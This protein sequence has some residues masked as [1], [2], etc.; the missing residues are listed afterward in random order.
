MSTSGRGRQRISRRNLLTGAGAGL[1][2]TA[3][4]GSPAAVAHGRSIHAP[5]RLRY[6]RQEANIPTPREQTVIIEMVQTNIFDSFNPYVPNGEAFQYGVNQICR[7]CMFYSNFVT[8][9]ITPWL[10]ERWEYNA[11][12]TE[13]TLSLNPNAK[14]NDGRPYTSD[15]VV[16]SFN[17][18]ANTPGLFG[19]Q[20]VLDNVASIS[21]P[22]P[23]TVVM[24]LKGSRPRFHY[25]FIAGIVFDGLKVVPRHIWEGQDPN[26]FANNPPVYTGPYVLDQVIPEQFMYI[27]R[28][29]PD[30]WNAATPRP[31]G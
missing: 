29:N 22:N 25:N 15:D 19:S 4:A 17:L 12:F 18:L 30:Y 6:S 3:V 10:A 27:W 26:T 5:T 1:A 24:P 9:E 2:A 13:L 21:A 8:G 23:Q 14:W 7:E 28:K 16:F 20:T 11:D 31:P